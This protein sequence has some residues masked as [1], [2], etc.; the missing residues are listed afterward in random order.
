MSSFGITDIKKHL[1][2]GLGLR[3][4]RYL[5]ELPVPTVNGETINILCQSA[6]LPER[7]I[8]TADLWH[9]GRRYTV[10]GETDYIGEYEISIVDDDRMKIRQLFDTWMKTIDNSR[11]DKNSSIL[12]ASFE[13]VNPGLLDN[14]TTGL[15]VANRVKGALTN[16]RQLLDFAI[17]QLDVNTQLASA[18]Y[19]TDINIWQMGRPTSDSFI[20]VDFPIPIDNQKIYGYKL[21]NAFPKSVGI[22]TLEDG[23][24]NTLSEFSVTF[25]FSEFIPLYGIQQDL[26]AGVLGDR[27]TDV[28]RGIRTLS[29]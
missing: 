14:L 11:P 5:I 16:P 10:R 19:Q 18:A 26:M 27:A 20:G 25:A 23:D 4:N 21:Q 29:Q 6:G 2:P 17:G 1:G 3:K 24:E 13:Q 8:S 22:V 12:G 7:N 9:K 28:I 15:E